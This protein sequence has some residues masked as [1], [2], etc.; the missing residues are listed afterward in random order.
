VRR[1]QRERRR[2]QARGRRPAGLARADRAR[3]GG[4]WWYNRTAAPEVNLD[5]FGDPWL[6]E[7]RAAYADLGREVWVL[8]VT[9][10]LDVPVMVAL[11]RR[12]DG[13]RENIML[14]FGAHLDPRIALRRALTELNQLMPAALGTDADG[15]ISTEDPDLARWWSN[16]T[17]ANQPY[18]RP[19]PAVPP[20]GP[21]D[22]RYLPSQDLLEDV[23]AVQAGFEARGLEVLVLDQSRPD[24][25]L[26]VVKVIVPGMRPFWAR[27]GP[28]RLFDVPVSLGRLACPTPYEEL[29]PIPMFL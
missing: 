3:R 16:A 6:D 28:G 8:D 19:D 21:R 11:S 4:T 7:I 9:S 20:R 26:P 10:D 14:G 24:V 1:L 22:Y 23:A 27:F 12:T 18:L 5:A 15:R 2:Q 25:G 13:G 17:M 29:N